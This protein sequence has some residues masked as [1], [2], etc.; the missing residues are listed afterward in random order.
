MSIFAH[1]DRSLYLWLTGLYFLSLASCTPARA[2][3]P[4]PQSD[5]A[6]VVPAAATE[7]NSTLP[8]EAAEAPSVDQ[9]IAG[10][11]FN[12]QGPA[13][14]PIQKEPGMAL[15]HLR[16]E[17]CG[18]LILS[19]KGQN[20]PHDP[21]NDHYQYFHEFQGEPGGEETI[22]LDRQTPYEDYDAPPHTEMLRI[23]EVSPDCNWELS[24][25]PMSAARTFSP[26]QTLSG[27]YDDVMRVAD[28]LQGMD[29]LF[30]N[31][32]HARMLQQFQGIHAILEDGSSICLD[33]QPEGE[34]YLFES[35]PA[36]TEYLVIYS[37]G[38]WELQGN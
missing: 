10:L 7:E 16:V 30:N 18:Y 38:Y 4:L 23:E 2:S 31:P 1:P 17:N 29:L 5:P 15:A 32:E 19:G 9:A 24:I 6:T 33:C 25:L 12:G 26:G 28:G 13:T 8:T 34:D 36:G 11:H 35:L 22:I 21:I 27:T 20:I 37:R 3:T 14:W